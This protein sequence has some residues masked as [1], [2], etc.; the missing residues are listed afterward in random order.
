MN[1]KT[2]ID[3]KEYSSLI[4]IS[5]CSSMK[6]EIMKGDP[7]RNRADVK[8]N[9]EDTLSVTRIVFSANEKYEGHIAENPKPGLKKP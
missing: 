7:K 5:G 9:I 8:K 3:R 4:R 1:R 2:T 6:G